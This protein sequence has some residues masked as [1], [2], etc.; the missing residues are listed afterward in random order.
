VKRSGDPR[1]RSRHRPPFP[2][3]RRLFHLGRYRPDPGREL[4]EELDFHFQE[5]VEELRRQ[6]MDPEQARA[7]AERRFGDVTGYR[8]R[9][10]RIDRDTVRMARWEEILFVL[11]QNIVHAARSLRHSPG[12]AAAVITILALGIWANVVMFGILERILLQPPPHIVQPEQVRKVFRTRAGSNGSRDTSRSLSYPDFEAMKTASSFSAAAAYSSVQDATIGRGESAERA[13]MT[14]VTPGFLPLL[15]VQPVLGRA[16]TPEDDEIGTPLTVLIGYGYW[17]QHFGADPDVLGRDLELGFG[18]FWGGCATATVIGV[19]P[20]GFTGVELEQIDLWLPLTATQAAQTGNRDWYTSPSW[21]FVRILVRER[22][23][24]RDETAAVEATQLYLQTHRQQIDEGKVD[25]GTRI[26]LGSL[27]AARGPDA[28]RESAVARWLGGVSLIVLLIACTN[29]VNL[30]LGRAVDRSR[31]MAVRLALGVSRGR[32]IGQ[33]IT[34][35]LMLAFLSGGIALLLTPGSAD[36]LRRVL[37]PQLY[38]PYAPVSGRIIGFTL[39]VSAITGLAAGFIPALQASRPSLSASI[40]SGDRG[41]SSRRSRIGLTLQVAQGALSVILLVGAGLFVRSLGRVHTLDL[42]IDV[43]RLVEVTLEMNDIDPPAAMMRERH[44]RAADRVSRIPDVE[45]VAITTSPLGWGL[46]IDISV[47]GLDS[48]PE[49]PTGSPTVHYVSPGYCGVLGLRLLSGRGLLPADGP[50]GDRSLVVNAFMARTIWPGRSA[51]GQTVMVET[52]IND[53][54]SAVAYTV[55]GVVEDASN[56]ELILDPEMQFYMP[57]DE[58]PDFFTARALYVRTRGDPAPLLGPIRREALAGDP[59][60]RY[61]KVAPVRE[62]FDPEARSWSLGA[63]M[64]TVFGLLALVVAATGLYSILS[65][66]VARRTR[67]IG[68]RTALGAR[69]GKLVGLVLGE[70]VRLTVV[71]LGLGFAVALAAARFVQPL[72]FQV[73][74]TDPLVYGTIAAVL[75]VTALAAGALPAWRVS[76]LDPVTALRSE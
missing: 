46:G 42:G 76:R 57:L 41:S 21:S 6:G 32:L 7:E 30:T 62:L 3:L 44:R 28:T 16:F 27:I 4:E 61:V 37:F 40:R 63:T 66:Q 51:V 50:S 8:S 34:E 29:V 74:A 68:I 36:F 12:F 70:G 19:L 14:T 67:E 73:S 72:L 18:G 47:P 71:G 13:R 60:L 25:A 54:G 15:G 38:W 33:L 22:P 11:R 23:G 64:F 24:T 2:G 9:L 35:S 49:P 20:R 56:G 58:A 43:D 26:L 17:Q 10:E 53:P 39:I 48:I 1:R 45:G 65:Y 59:D 31:E 69:R 5:T 52:R 75:L 55:V